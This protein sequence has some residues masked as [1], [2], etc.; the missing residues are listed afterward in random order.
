MRISLDAHDI[1]A[2]VGLLDPICTLSELDWLNGN[3]DSCTSLARLC[4]S[5]QDCLLT[6]IDLRFANVRRLKTLSF[7]SSF[8]LSATVVVFMN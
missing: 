3:S 5:V 1:T 2:F 7:A 4:L 6:G 8:W